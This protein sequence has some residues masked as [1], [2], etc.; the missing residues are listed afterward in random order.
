MAQ[1][2]GDDRPHEGG[3]P[4]GAGVGAGG[5]DGHGI[6]VAAGDAL[7]E[8]Q[9]ARDG[10]HASARSHVENPSRAPAL[11]SAFERLETPQRRAMMAGAESERRLDLDADVVRPPPRPV[12]RAMHQHAAGAHRREARKRV[13]D[14][15]L[16]GD[17]RKTRRSRSVGVGRD[18]DQ[19][20]NLGLVGRAGEIDLDR[21]LRPAIFFKGRGGGLGR[22]E[23]LDDD[24]G[25]GAGA[26][27]VAGKAQHMAGAVRGKPFKH[28][29]A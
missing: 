16:L 5:L 22:I 27:L 3:R 13:F 4:I 21:P 7:M 2:P 20:A 11:G 17:G 26:P 28:G 14:P 25:D 10:E 6:D 8:E 24:V 19:G 15:I 9:G 23:R 12:M 29:G 1:S 18:R